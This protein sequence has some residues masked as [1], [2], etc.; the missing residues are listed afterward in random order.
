MKKQFAALAAVLALCLAGCGAADPGSA[1]H[2]AP[3]QSAPGQSALSQSMPSQSVPD[4]LG[5]MEWAIQPAWEF[6]AVEPVA[7][8]ATLDAGVVSDRPGEAGYYLAKTA[9]GWGV[10]NTADGTLAAEG[11]FATQPTRCSKGHLYDPGLS[12]AGR[13]YSPEEIQA[14]DAALEAIGTSYR[15][16]VGH[17]GGA[18]FLLANEAGAVSAVHFSEVG[19][20]LRPLDQEEGLPGLVPL[21]Q[22]ALRDDWAG[23]E[24]VSRSDFVLEHE[25]RFAVASS[26]GRLL[27]DFVYENACMGTSEAIAVC[28]EGRWGYVDASGSEIIPCEYDP[29]WGVAWQWDQETGMSEPVAGVYPA[30]FTE[31][32]VVVKQGGRT[33]VLRADG[34]WLLEMGAA[35]DAAPAWGGLLWVKAGGRWGALKLG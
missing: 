3:G 29:F 10:L 7:D 12:D 31:G 18:C 23:A 33:G 26:D 24:P 13:E 6:E 22:G 4:T 1:A 27:T 32:C 34:S 16:E 5:G 14:L 15:M 17:G 2:S 25:G 30:P 35:E 11:A 21:Q 8:T 19:M 28:R 20:S 9:A